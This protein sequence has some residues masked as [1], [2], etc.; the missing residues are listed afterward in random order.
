MACILKAFEMEIPRSGYGVRKVDRLGSEKVSEKCGI[1][2]E[3]AS[4]L[5]SRVLRWQGH[6]EMIG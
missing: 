6:T 3:K 4:E 1:V 5:K 2:K